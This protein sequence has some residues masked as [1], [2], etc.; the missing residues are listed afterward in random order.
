[1]APLD[2]EI[3]GGGGIGPQVIR[4]VP[5]GNEADFFRSLRIIFSAACLFHLDWIS[6]SRTSPSVSTARRNNTGNI[7]APSGKE[8]NS[9]VTMNQRGARRSGGRNNQS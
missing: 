4:D 5:I 1:M 9:M 2:P 8:I 6:T 7:R 3:A